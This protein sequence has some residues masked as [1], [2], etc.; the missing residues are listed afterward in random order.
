MKIGAPKETFSGEKRVA[1]TP[2]SAVALKK[3]GYDCLVEAGAGEQARFSDDAYAE[4][5]VE[6]V[7]SQASGQ[8]ID[9]ASARIARSSCSPIPRRR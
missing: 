2:Q 5:G 1:L 6:V 4:A 3:L 8:P 9:F 7:P